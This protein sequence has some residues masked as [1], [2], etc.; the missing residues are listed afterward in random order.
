[1]FIVGNEYRRRD[2]HAKYSGQQQG[3][4]CTPARFPLIFILQVKVVISLD[5]LMTGNLWIFFITQEKDKKVI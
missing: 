3:S 1:M 2:I 4:I 5:T